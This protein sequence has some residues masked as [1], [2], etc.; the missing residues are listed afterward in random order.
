MENE[1]FT[2]DE[3]LK[4]IEE[5]LNQ[6]RGT[7]T[8]ASFYYILWGAVFFIYYF[9]QFLTLKIPALIDSGLNSFNWVVFPIGGLLSI[10]NKRKDERTEIYISHFEK[11]Y[12]WG[13]TGFAMLYGIV[14]SVSIFSLSNLAIVLYPALLG[15]TVYTVGGITKHWPS[16]YG[17]ILGL[18]FTLISM[19]SDLEFQ[20][21]CASLASI[22]CCLIPGILMRKSNV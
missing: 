1:S 19:R 3:S 22:F 18:V 10:L 2:A 17:G 8:G 14:F 6:T 5:A 11:I 4:T 7:K 9:I 16:V 13:F 12:F 21:L 20:Y 15:V